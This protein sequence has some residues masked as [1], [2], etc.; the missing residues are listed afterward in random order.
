MQWERSLPSGPS[1]VV[2][3]VA[4][5]VGIAILGQEG[6][7]AINCDGGFPFCDLQI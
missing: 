3:D 6:D 2:R 5:Y 7:W 4:A 1:L